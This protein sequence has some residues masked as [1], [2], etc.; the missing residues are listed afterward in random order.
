MGIP[1]DLRDFGRGFA[2]DSQGFVKRIGM[3]IYETLGEDLCK[4]SW[5]LH[6]RICRDFG[7]GFMQ[8]FAEI[9]E[10]LMRLW[11]RICEDPLGFMRLCERI[12]KHT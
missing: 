11:E 8:G 1:E 9:H 6:G 3:R 2:M 12:H 7:R 5:R 10:D 4:D